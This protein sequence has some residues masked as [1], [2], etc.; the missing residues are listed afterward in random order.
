MYQSNP[1]E[2]NRDAETF[3]WTI[4]PTPVAWLVSMV[5][6]LGVARTIKWKE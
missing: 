3:F 6:A 5:I 4:A 2:A 1:V